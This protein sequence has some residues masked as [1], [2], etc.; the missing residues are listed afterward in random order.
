LPASPSWVAEGAVFLWNAALG[1]YQPATPVLWGALLAA[2]AQGYIFQE[3]SAGAGAVNA[4]TSLLAIERAAPAATALT[5]PAVALRNAKP[6]QIV[7]WSTAVVAHAI[8][9]TPAAGETIMRLGSSELFSTPDQL[10]GITLYPSIDLS[11]WV[12]AP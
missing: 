10:A 6:L 5:L 7:D 9:L 11:G 12:I 3:V 1:S 8:T 4:A 2:Y